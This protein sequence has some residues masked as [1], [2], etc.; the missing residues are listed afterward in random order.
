MHNDAHSQYAEIEDPFIS[1][2]NGS[3]RWTK[4]YLDGHRISQ[5]LSPGAPLLRINMFDT[6][7]A[8]DIQICQHL[9][10]LCDVGL[11]YV[12]KV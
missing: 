7:L 10:I 5:V 12:L 3:F 8:I 6:H 1:I 9:P 2:R 4:W 11:F